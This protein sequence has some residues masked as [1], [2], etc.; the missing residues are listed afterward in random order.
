MS[1]PSTSG[2]AARISDRVD[3]SDKALGLELNINRQSATRSASESQSPVLVLSCCSGHGFKFA[4]IIGEIAAD[5]L[6]GSHTVEGKDS[7]GSVDLSLFTFQSH[8]QQ[9]T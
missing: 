4:S 6:E 7:Q 3:E 5:M 9:Q 8:F 1:I 2:G